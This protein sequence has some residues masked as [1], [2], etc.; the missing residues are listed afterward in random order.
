MRPVTTR[1]VDLRLAA[2]AEMRP[3][4]EMTLAELR[5]LAEQYRALGRACIAYAGGLDRYADGR[6][7]DPP[8]R[9]LAVRERMRGGQ[10]TWLSRLSVWL[11]GIIAHGRV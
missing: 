2:P 8:P 11:A 1:G 5:T 3:R 9:P 10:R 4:S 6:T 7:E